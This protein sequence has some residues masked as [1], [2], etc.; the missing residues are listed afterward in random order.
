MNFK[1]EVDNKTGPA[2]LKEKNKWQ[3]ALRRYIIEKQRT[4]YYAPYF[5]IDILRFRIWIELQFD[6]GIN[7]ENFGKAWQFDHVVPVGY[8][9]FK[10]EVDLKLCWNFTNISVDM[11]N[12]YP[13][14]GKRVDVLTAKA[15]FLGIYKST[16][17]SICQEMIKKIERIENSQISKNDKQ[18]AFITSNYNYLEAIEKFSVYEF[19]QLNLG[20]GIDEIKLEKQMLAQFK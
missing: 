19:E 14:T 7:W 2:N 12:G 17:Y 6:R 5:G 8:F 13:N 1:D 10:S 3:I 16:G 15:Y 4:S 20:V 18:E 9:D 11:A